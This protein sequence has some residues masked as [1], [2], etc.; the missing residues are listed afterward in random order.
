[1]ELLDYL[2]ESVARKAS[3]VFIITNFP[4]SYRIDGRIVSN[5]ENQVKAEIDAAPYIE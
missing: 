3:D 2:E 4:C 1:M 5:V